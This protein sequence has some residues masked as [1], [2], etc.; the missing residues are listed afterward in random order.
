MFEDKIEK[1]DVPDVALIKLASA[2]G[3]LFLITVWP[4]AMNLV[5]K[6]PWGWFLGAMIVFAARPFYKGWIKK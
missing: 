6:I 4:A 1:I 5:H 3:I 2:S